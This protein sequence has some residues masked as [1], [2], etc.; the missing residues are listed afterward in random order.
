MRHA[1]LVLGCC[2][3]LAAGDADPVVTWVPGCLAKVYACGTAEV[4]NGQEV[5]PGAGWP[6]KALPDSPGEVLL[7]PA[8]P[9]VESPT[10]VDLFIKTAP[11]NVLLPK[12]KML[13]GVNFYAVEFEGYYLAASE[14][15]Y[16]IA[17]AS[18]DPL[19]IYVEGKLIAKDETF[20]D[21]NK[22][23]MYHERDWV[24]TEVIKGTDPPTMATHA[25]HGSVKLSPNRY[26]HVVI[27]NRQQWYPASRVYLA[28]STDS[29]F[30]RD[31]NRGAYFKAW[32][33]TPDNKTTPLQLYLP[34]A[35]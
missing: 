23:R 28:G 31:L 18:D 4:G 3:L 5:K 14:G 19:E 2:T 1:L 32:A 10:A 9:T 26:Y 15:V 20:A 7:L 11:T 33:T 29:Y 35:K 25:L 21:P 6:I 13:A 16:A 30:A 24:K 22:G 8:V 12:S 27:V 17:A 34:Q